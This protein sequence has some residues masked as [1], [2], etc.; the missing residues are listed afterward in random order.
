MVG[1]KGSSMSDADRMILGIDPGTAIMGYGLIGVQQNSP[2]VITYGVIQLNQYQDHMVKL[3]KAF[4]RSLNLIETYI[5]DEL[6]IEAPFYGKNVQ[7]M[8]K[9]GRAQGVAMAAGLYRD[10]PIFEYAPK[11]I[12]QS[13]TGKGG[14]SKEQVAGMLKHLLG[15]PSI[16][17][18]LDATDGLATALC[19]FYKGGADKAQTK[20]TYNSWASFVNNNP[21]RI[22]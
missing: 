8:L 5:P 12:K 14:A 13:I 10:I 3:R 20:A 6:A 4:E 11:R 7:S 9:L 17:D 22:G 1:N 2:F 19:H 18:H 21:G 15:T 16:P